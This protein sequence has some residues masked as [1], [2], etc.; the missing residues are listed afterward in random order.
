MDVAPDETQIRGGAEIRQ[1]LSGSAA[2]KE[3]RALALGAK[4]DC[5]ALARVHG[6]SRQAYPGR[7][8][9]LMLPSVVTCPTACR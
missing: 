4:S 9:L 1:V 5:V 6:L 2:E 7:V 3:P 8:A